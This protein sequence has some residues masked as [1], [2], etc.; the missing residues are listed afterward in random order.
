MIGDKKPAIDP[1]A[2]LIPE[3]Q[4]YVRFRTARALKNTL[5]FADAWGGS[6][7]AQAEVGGRDYRVRDKLEQQ[8][9]LRSSLLSDLLGPAV[10]ESLAITGADPYLREGSDLSIVFQ[11]K[12][13]AVFEPAVARYIDEARRRY[14]PLR[15]AREDYEAVAIQSFHTADAAVRCYRARLGE[16]YVYSNSPAAIRR[17]IDTHAGRRPALARSLDFVY[18]RTLYPLGAKEEDGF[19]FLSDPFIRTLCGPR[20]RIAEKRRIEA[21]TS[22][23]LIRN[24]ALLYLFEHPGAAVPTL[25]R[26]FGDGYI[27]REQVAAEPGDQIAWNP[28]QV[29]AGST[30]YGRLGYL[31]PNVELPV[32]KVTATERREYD[33]FRNQYQSYWRQFFDPIGI[34][35]SAGKDMAIAMTILPL[36]NNSEYNQVK[37]VAGGRVVPLEPVRRRGP[38]VLHLTSHLNP[39]SSLV[40]EVQQVSVSALGGN[41]AAVEWLGE[42]IEFW[43][44][45]SEH[46]SNLTLESL[47]G[48]IFKVPMVLAVEVKNP[49]G[50]ATFLTAMRTLIQTSAPNTVLFDPLEPYREFTFTRIRPDARGPVGNGE[51]RDAAI[52]Y[53][54]VGDYLYVSTALAPLQRIVDT[55]LDTKQAPGAA[56]PADLSRQPVAEAFGAAPA[57]HMALRIDPRTGEKALPAILAYLGGQALDTEREHLRNLWL[58]ARTVG[59]GPAAKLPAERVL[60]YAIDSAVGGTYAYD[61]ARDEVANSLTGSLWNP[62]MQDRLPDQSPLVQLIRSLDKIRATIEF[63]SD[64][65]H[66]ELSVRRAPGP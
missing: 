7:L 12:T 62:S 38:V 63:T 66:T 35:I 36:I 13:P 32:E 20:L 24:A 14:P 15:E 52:Y 51:F 41:R 16:F 46:L 60:G 44:E 11:L 18:M 22:L 10:I 29:A 33:Q 54:V 61:P 1:I 25:D 9:C 26:L 23:E 58:V 34:R 27:A 48:K 50:L 19:V 43:I 21:V 64:G 57:G 39:T 55:H 17:I 37:E 42:R 8:L 56:G 47:F 49:L 30:S 59:L 40:R 5:E 53:G 31:T 3:D 6:V 28:A 2:G 45:D 4:Y 65:L